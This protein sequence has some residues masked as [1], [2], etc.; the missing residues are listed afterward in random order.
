MLMRREGANN[1]KIDLGR[2]RPNEA[3]TRTFAGSDGEDDGKKGVGGTQDR[4]SSLSFGVGTT[5]KL[6]DSPSVLRGASE[7]G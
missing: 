7:E 1:D 2:I 5:G 6:Q 4:M 3:V